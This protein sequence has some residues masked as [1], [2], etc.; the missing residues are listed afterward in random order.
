MRR[1]QY[2]RHFGH[3]KFL[4]LAEAVRQIIEPIASNRSPLFVAL[5]MCLQ[6]HLL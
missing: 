4:K 2:W 3:H 5:T 6:R 1:C